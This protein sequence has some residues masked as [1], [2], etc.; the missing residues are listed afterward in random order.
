MF[1]MAVIDDEQWVVRSLMSAI[2]PQQ[3]FELVGEAY[4]GVSGLRLLEDKRPGLAFVNTHLP[5]I[6]G[7]DLLQTAGE[8]RLPTLFIMLS[9]HTDFVYLQKA[10]FHNAISYCLKPFNSTELME[11]L[12]K[13]N[14]ILLSQNAPP[15]KPAQPTA[16]GPGVT[17]IAE[18]EDTDSFSFTTNQ[19]V[20]RMLTFLH[21]NYRQSISVQDLANLCSINQSYA[22]QLF[23]QEIGETVSNYLAHIRIEKAAILLAESDLSIA[24]VANDVGYRD[25]FYFAKVFKKLVGTTPSAYR[26][27]P[28]PLNLTNGV[29][30]L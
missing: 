12:E 24:A 21:G 19:M 2:Q 17:N 29:Y 1:Q 26:A 7:L 8:R 27:N 5:G 25:Y 4:D 30:P 18:P 6:S 20:N 16:G 14:K 15:S 28:F 22:G 10:I 11:S 23:R 9:R 3:W 13:A